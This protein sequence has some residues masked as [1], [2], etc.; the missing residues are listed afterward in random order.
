MI[1]LVNS[2]FSKNNIKRNM[3]YNINLKEQMFNFFITK[4]FKRITN[5]HPEHSY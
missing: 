1:R 2:C 5:F 3:P 4:W